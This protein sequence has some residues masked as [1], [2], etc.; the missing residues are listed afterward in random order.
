MTAGAP[1]A[2]LMR[3]R[4]RL[5]V[6]VVGIVLLVNGVRGGAPQPTAAQATAAPGAAGVRT[7]V[8]ESLRPPPTA[9]A[10]PRSRTVPVRLRIPAIAVDAPMTGLGL[11]ADG[12]LEVPPAE[13]ADTAGWYA[14]GPAPGEPGTAVVAGHVDSPAGRAVFYL[15]G[16]L[17]RGSAITV[18]RRD[19]RTV[20]FSVYAVEAY[21]KDAFPS[22]KVYR[23]TAAPELRVITCG[24]G[25]REGTGYLGNVVVY[26]SLAEPPR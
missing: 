22:R 17:A 13:R 26:A 25:Y 2:P 1:G 8:P 24:G 5:A 11:D 23:S 12:A 20:R 6:L 3:P 19:G 16:G 7:G 10:E 18:T 4:T 9:P 15:L 14:D 21:D